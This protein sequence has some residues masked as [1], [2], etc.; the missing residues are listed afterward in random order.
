M[1]FGGAFYAIT[2]SQLK[3]LLDRSLDGEAFIKG[4]T[5][6]APMERFSGGEAVWYELTKLLG[7][8]DGC[9]ATGTEV[10]PEGGAYSY[11][12]EVARISDQLTMLNKRELQRRYAELET[13]FRFEEVYAAI[14]GLLSFYR[15][16][17]KAGLAILFNIG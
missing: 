4:R 12:N 8:E 1:S 5:A 3:R 16:S 11:A 13:T 10:I 17:S 14:V 2:D 15:R 6:E 9:G 7:P